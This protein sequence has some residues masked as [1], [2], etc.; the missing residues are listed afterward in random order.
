MMNLVIRPL[1]VA[2][3]ASVALAGCAA[4]RTLNAEEQAAIAAAGQRAADKL[5]ESS[6]RA[7]TAQA[8]LARIQEAR[9][10]PAPRPFDDTLTG[11]P[12]ELRRA[13]TLEWSGPGVE[14]A[15]RVATI[16]GY[17]FRIVGNPPANPVSVHVS[18]RESSAA[19]VLEDIGLQ[20]QPFGQVVVDPNTRRI[21]YRYLNTAGGG[22]P[23][24]RGMSK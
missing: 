14:A 15:R 1:A 8:E 13:V 16:I 12:S 5:A 9:T 3:L 19:K 6:E 21:E 22:R 7:A 11:V 20:S 18:Q 24:P 10:R 2:L 4:Q 17:E 23:I